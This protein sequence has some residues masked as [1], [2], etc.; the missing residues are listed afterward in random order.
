M[1]KQ[2]LKIKFK[3]LHSDVKLPVKGSSHAACFDVYAHSITYNEKDPRKR[4]VGLGFAT[5]IPEGYCGILIPRSNLTKFYW[6]LN[7]S[8]GIIDSDYRGEYK[9]IF[10][11]IT[12][13]AWLYPFPY[14]EG[15]RVGQIYFEEI[16]NVEFEEVDELDESDRGAGGFGSTGT[17]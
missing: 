5:E 1:K 4:I 11:N 8:I 13:N 12:D 16:T 15:E 3:K 6:I 17:K 14:E 10:T 9:M 7:N 2:S